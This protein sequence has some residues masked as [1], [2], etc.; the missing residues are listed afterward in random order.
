MALLVL[1]PLVPRVMKRTTIY[2]ILI[3]NE[4][5][6]VVERGTCITNR[7]LMSPCNR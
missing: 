6:F 5:R 7:E 1:D 4:L 2:R 3:G